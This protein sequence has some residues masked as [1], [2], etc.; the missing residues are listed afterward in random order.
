MRRSSRP[1]GLR[2]SGRNHCFINCAVQALFFLTTAHDVTEDLSDCPRRS[3]SHA[4]LSIMCEMHSLSKGTASVDRLRRE[5]ANKFSSSGLFQDRDFGDPYEAYSAILQLLY[6]EIPNSKLAR[7]LRLD[8]IEKSMCRCNQLEQPWSPDTFGIS[9]YLDGS[10]SLQAQLDEDIQGKTI[11]MCLGTKTSCATITSR[12]FREVPQ[13]LVLQLNGAPLQLQMPSPV[14]SKGA[15]V[16]PLGNSEFYFS[17]AGRTSHHRSPSY[18]QPESYEHLQLSSLH[19]WYDLEGVIMRSPEHFL[20]V[21]KSSA[22]WTVLDDA[23]VILHR[24]TCF[25]EILQYLPSATPYVLFYAKRAQHTAQSSR[26][27]DLLASPPIPKLVQSQPS[28]ASEWHR[29]L[30]K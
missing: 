26:Q 20:T 18:Q 22:G 7:K 16:R 2:N 27:T 25:L 10:K 15:M 13:V 1:V 24:T 30:R 23:L 8:I 9:V 3:V 29:S 21:C 17:S 12:K 14:N 6:T 4:L 19:T 11:R 28:N 5:L